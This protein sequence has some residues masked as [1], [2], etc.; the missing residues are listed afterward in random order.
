MLPSTWQPY[1]KGKTP[2]QQGKPHTPRTLAASGTHLI[3]SLLGLNGFR[4][5]S[6]RHPHSIDHPRLL[7]PRSLSFHMQHLIAVAVHIEERLHS[8]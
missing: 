2:E 5:C 7:R 1:Y 8:L 6:R 3:K 4:K